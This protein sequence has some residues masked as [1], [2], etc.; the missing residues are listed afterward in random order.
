MR[1]S[2]RCFSETILISFFRFLQDY[3][4][5]QNEGFQHLTVNHTKTIE[6]IW[7]HAKASMNKF[8][9][10]KMLFSGYLAKYMFLKA[11]RQEDVDPTGKLFT[12]IAKL[13]NPLSAWPADN[14][15]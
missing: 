4:G 15:A 9:T 6:S 10:K 2:G 1:D 8:F 7:R 3:S 5:L 12:M 14:V 13:Y 11:Y